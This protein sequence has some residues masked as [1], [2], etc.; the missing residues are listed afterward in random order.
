ME[1]KDISGLENNDIREGTKC[2][3]EYTRIRVSAVAPDY[4]VGSYQSV[5]CTNRFENINEKYFTLLRY[6]I[7]EL[8]P[9]R[10]RACPFPGCTGGDITAIQCLNGNLSPYYVR[11]DKCNARGPTKADRVQA[12]AAWGYQD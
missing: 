12:E 8:P 11:C 1:W 5:R 9:R 10:L 2:L 7:I 3:V 4:I 6:C